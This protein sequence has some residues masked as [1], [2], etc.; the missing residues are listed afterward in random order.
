[1]LSAHAQS[2]LPGAFHMLISREREYLDRLL[3]GSDFTV[4]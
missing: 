4:Q 3:G 1:M 2:A